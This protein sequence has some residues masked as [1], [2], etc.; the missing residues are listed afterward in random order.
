MKMQNLVQG[1]DSFAREFK[2]LQQL[3]FRLSF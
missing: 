1:G 2:Q 3:S